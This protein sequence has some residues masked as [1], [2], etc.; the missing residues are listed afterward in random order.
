MITIVSELESALT[1][2]PTPIPT[3]AIVPVTGLVSCASLNDCW[4]STTVACAVSMVASSEAIVAALS[5]GEVLPEP[6]VRP[7]PLLP[8]P[9]RS[10]PSEPVLVVDV[11]GVV[12]EPEPD[13]PVGTVEDCSAANALANVLS[14][15]AT[16]V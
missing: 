5:L 2:V 12:D 13:E 7:E 4:A 16:V 9:E 11:A 10:E 1:V 3:E 15:V 14:S 8:S 6:P